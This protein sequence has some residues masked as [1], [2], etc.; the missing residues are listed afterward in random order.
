[1]DAGYGVL[2]RVLARRR[3]APPQAQNGQPEDE[4]C[5][6]PGRAGAGDC[7]AKQSSGVGKADES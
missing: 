5:P 6:R 3:E 7:V 4:L 1:M 2:R